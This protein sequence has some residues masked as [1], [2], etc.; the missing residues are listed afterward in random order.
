MSPIFTNLSEIA[1]SLFQSIRLSFIIPSFVFWFLNAL[2]IY[3]ILPFPLKELTRR[4]IGIFSLDSFTLVTVL[5]LVGGYF[6][7][8]LNTPI[9]RWFEGYP[10]RDY[11]GIDWFYKFK[12]QYHRKRRANLMFSYKCEQ[13]KEQRLKDIMTE[14]EELLGNQNRQF[15]DEIYFKIIEIGI[16]KAMYEKELQRLYPISK[17]PFLP[18]RLGNAIASFEDYSQEKYGID[19]V[20]IWSRFLPVLSQVK[21]SLYLEREKANFDLLINLCLVAILFC[22]E[23][24]IV[25]LIF[26]GNFIELLSI[27]GI[28]L[29]VAYFLYVTALGGALGWGTT[30]KIAFDLYRYELMQSLKIKIPSNQKE[31]KETWMKISEHF[32]DLEKKQPLNIDYDRIDRLIVNVVPPVH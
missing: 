11:I 22:A 1:T 7:F 10:W 15:I 20:V 2:F 5:S 23:L 3:D 31:E 12:T 17:P 16:I 26:V 28:G 9:I 24:F 29:C 6:L 13:Q 14:T 18:T 27:L 4:L 19:S 32:R 21:Y 30:V 25:S 8:V